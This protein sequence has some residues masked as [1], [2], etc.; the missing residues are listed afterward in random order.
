MIREPWELRGIG[1]DLGSFLQV[2][3]GLGLF[4]YE[5]PVF[6]VAP[7]ALFAF[8]ATYFCSWAKVGKNRWLPHAAPAL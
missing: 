5:Y 8:T 7:P 2:G 1:G 4:L 6:V 3:L